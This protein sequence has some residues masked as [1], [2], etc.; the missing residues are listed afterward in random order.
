MN[1]VVVVGGGAA[2]LMAAY[3]AAKNGANVTIFEK[4]E[5]CGKKLYI[6]G[7]GRCNL[8]NNVSLEAFMQNIVTNPKFLFGALKAFSPQDTIEFFTQRGCPLKV[9]RG[10][11]VFPDSDK[12]SDII[13]T[14]VKAAEKEGVSIKTLSAVKDISKT[15]VGYQITLADS[16]KVEA[17]CVIITTGGMSYPSTGSTGDGYI[18]GEKLGHKIIKPKAALA[19]IKIKDYDGEL[20][21]LSLKN[22]TLSAFVEGKKSISLF[23]EMLFTAVGISG[24]ITLSMSSYINRYE[25][26]KVAFEIDFKPALSEDQLDKRILR[27]FA[28]I[29]NKQFKNSLDQLLPSLLIPKI[30]KLSKIPE[31]KRV[32]SIT[33]EERRKLIDL[34][35]HFKI[36]PLEDPDIRAGIVTSGGIN[37]KE[38]EPKTMESKLHKGLY[39]AGEVLDIDAL[40]GGYNIQIALSS[41]YLAGISASLSKNN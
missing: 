34:L 18:F 31:Y 5:K 41:G 22:V 28:E 14:L 15:E 40:T 10:G 33:K 23:G 7:K 30:I 17:D 20:E 38:I 25:I 13:N 39:F 26:S 12:S 24:P 35:K 16:T 37:V 2:G 36:E 3:S 9:E 1:K 8:T 19:P 29:P 21:G 6:T 32:N 4:N 27:D 11:R